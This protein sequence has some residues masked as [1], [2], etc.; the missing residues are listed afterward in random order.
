M[1]VAGFSS[2]GVAI[3]YVIPVLW[4]T[5]YFHTLLAAS[6][7]IN[8]KRLNYLTDLSSSPTV[9]LCVGRSVGLSV[10]KVYCDGNTAKWIEMV[11]GV[12]RGMG[13]LDGVVMVEGERG[14]F[15]VNLGRPI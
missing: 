10:R 3:C 1:A 2:G 12:G 5:S 13:V 9:G 8:R 14:S 11:S 6:L 15:G 7:T 4:M